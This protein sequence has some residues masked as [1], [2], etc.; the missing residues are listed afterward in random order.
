MGLGYGGYLTRPYGYRNGQQPLTT[1]TQLRASP[2]I[3][4]LC[5]ALTRLD[6]SRPNKSRPLILSWQQRRDFRIGHLNLVDDDARPDVSMDRAPVRHHVYSVT[7]R[8]RFD[9]ADFQRLRAHQ[10]Y[11]RLHAAQRGD[12]ILFT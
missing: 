6:R 1:N 11:R 2:R 12:G 9:C 10:A 3:T 4:L 7:G 5:H 8:V